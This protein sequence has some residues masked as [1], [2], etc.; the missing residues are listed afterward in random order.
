MNVKRPVTCKDL[1]S[2]HIITLLASMA[3]TFAM[4]FT[5]YKVIE[6]SDVEDMTVEEQSRHFH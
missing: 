1:F 3:Q 5:A 4:F 2:I 6:E